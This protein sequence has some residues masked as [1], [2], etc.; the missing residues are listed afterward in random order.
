MITKKRS[1][2]LADKSLVATPPTKMVKKEDSGAA[3]SGGKTPGSRKH[4]GTPTGSS[5]RVNILLEF[6]KMAEKVASKS[7]KV[8]WS[9]L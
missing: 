3:V 2:L 1:S 5:S 4:V 7:L 9:I 8:S 6:R